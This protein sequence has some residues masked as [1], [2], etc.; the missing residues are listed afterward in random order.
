MKLETKQAYLIKKEED[1]KKFCSEL[2]KL[3]MFNECNNEYL[4]ESS[5]KEKLNRKYLRITICSN[6]HCVH[7]GY[8]KTESLST[9]ALTEYQRKNTCYQ[10]PC[11]L[12][13]YAKELKY[14][15]EYV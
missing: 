9:E 7:G 11:K 5:I 15:K 8:S 10:Y 12:F 3:G 13:V 4:L 14:N 1:L 2:K 6:G